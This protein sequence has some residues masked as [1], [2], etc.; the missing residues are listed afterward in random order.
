MAFDNLSRRSAEELTQKL[1]MDID[2]FDEKKKL[3]VQSMI[4]DQ[5]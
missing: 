3:I 2:S 4:N 5:S 1:K